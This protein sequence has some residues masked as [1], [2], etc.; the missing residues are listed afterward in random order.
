[1]AGQMAGAGAA[2]GTA[3]MPGLGTAIGMLAG[4][5]LDG[6]MTGSS[7]NATTAGPTSA[8]VAVYGSGLNAD[9]WAVNFSGTQT[10]TA[11][12]DKTLTASGPTA[13]T[14][15]QGAYAVPTLPGMPMQGVAGLAS[16][17][18]FDSQAVQAVP[19]WAWAAIAGIVLWRLKSRK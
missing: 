15:A 2:I 7:S 6:G 8:A 1:M 13:A 5:L 3:I 4:G 16:G 18:G 19:L 10:V 14:A 12:A 11:R 17:L 9:N